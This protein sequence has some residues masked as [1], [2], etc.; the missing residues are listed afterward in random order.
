MRE[1]E[2]IIDDV[3]AAL[4]EHSAGG[5]TGAFVIAA[6]LYDQNGR[7]RL[8]TAHSTDGTSW[9]LLG[10]VEAL[11]IDTQALFRGGQETG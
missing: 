9:T 6:E 4:A 2:S 3:H 7:P 5:M 8:F 10:M 1:P 11:R